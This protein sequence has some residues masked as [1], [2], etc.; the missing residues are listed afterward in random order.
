[1]KTEN[2][3]EL[4]DKL[5]LDIRYKGYKPLKPDFLY[6]VE[7]HVALERSKAGKHPME[8]LSPSFD[9]I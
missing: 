1:M 7:F 6:E 3:K 8:H 9:H 4:A 2:L 5:N